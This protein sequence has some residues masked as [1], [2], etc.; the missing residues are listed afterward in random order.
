MK[1]LFGIWGVHW[2]KCFY[3]PSVVYWYSRHLCSICGGSICQV[4]CTGIQGIYALF[5][6]GLFAK[7]CLSAKCC[8]LVC[9]ASMLYLWGSIC[10]SIFNCQMLCTGFKASV[11]YYLGWSIGQS[12]FIC[13]ILC[14]GIQ[15]ISPLLPEGSI[16]QSRFI[17]QV[18]CI[19]IQV[20]SP[21]LFGGGGSSANVFLSAKFCVLVF[22]A[23]MLYVWGVHLPKCVHLPSVV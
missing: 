23:S 12:M 8:V 3:L 13:H 21:L 1:F 5:V 16:A 4:L 14:T 6:G 20:I 18:L 2:Q 17:C 11:L 10:Q 19:S 9:K 15:V 22:K 7:V